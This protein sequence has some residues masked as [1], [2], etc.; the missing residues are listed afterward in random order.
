MDSISDGNKCIKNIDPASFDG[1]GLTAVSV[2]PTEFEFGCTLGD[3]ERI[4]DI[5]EME[6]RTI[7]SENTSLLDEKA[8]AVIKFQ[9]VNIVEEG[10]SL[11]FRVKEQGGLI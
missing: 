6:S 11:L 4:E 1:K 5:L 10:Y 8:I 7:N 2:I 9:L 3:N